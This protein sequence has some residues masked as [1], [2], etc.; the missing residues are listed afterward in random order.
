MR[1]GGVVPTGT[2]RRF[3]VDELIVSKT[4]TRGIITYA[5]DVLIR[6]PDMPRA[7]FQ[8]RW[9]TLKADQE[10]FAYINN[11]SEDGAHYWVPAHVTPSHDAGGRVVG[12]HSNR[13]VPDRDAVVAADNLY[14]SMRGRTT[15]PAP[16][17]R[18]RG[19]DGTV[20]TQARGTRP[21]LRPVRG[22]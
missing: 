7:V 21:D 12:Y 17:G 1:P 13:R 9:D 11:L 19:V 3:D 5:N 10:I 22:A 8:L 2:E 14:A 15:P 16:R 4:D 6:H 20:R 18:D